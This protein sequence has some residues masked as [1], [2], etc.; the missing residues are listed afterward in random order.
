MAEFHDVFSRAKY[1]DI[2][3]WRDVTDEVTFI[4]NLYQR[5]L[6]RP[7]RSFLD[8]ACG[9]GYHARIMA[10][11]GVKSIGLDLMPEMVEYARR[12][13]EEEGVAVH[14][15]AADMRTV[16][17]PEPV[18]FAFTS[19]DSLDCLHTYDE[20]IPHLETMAANLTPGGLYMIEATHLKSS[21]LSAYGD[22]HYEGQRN[23]TKVRIDWAINN[24]KVDPV[25]QVADV[26][27]LMRVVDDGREYVITDRARERFYTAQEYIALAKACGALE[28][29]D[30][31]GAF[32]LDTKFDWSPAS[33]RCLVLMQKKQ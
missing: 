17:L 29:V 8:N 15:I 5:K 32:D 13:A 7:L 33:Q 4:Q 28:V 30:F 12:R 10:K 24:P 26:E 14:W 3:F 18:D 25:T 16:R 2:A 19:F 11:R 6:G 20:I 27:V 1:Y 9:P 31:F 21:S 23:G 22:F